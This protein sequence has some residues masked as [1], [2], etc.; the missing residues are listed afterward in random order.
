TNGNPSCG[1]MRLEPAQVI[2]LRDARAEHEV[3][4]SS[5]ARDREI[6][7]QAPLVVEHRRERQSA[8]ARHAVGEDVI[9]PIGGAWPAYFVSG[10]G[11]DLE[12]ADGIAHRVTFGGDRTVRV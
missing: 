6:A 8:F 9:E 4:F 3:A 1:Q 11:R 7:D 12:Q 5:R 10:E 2:L